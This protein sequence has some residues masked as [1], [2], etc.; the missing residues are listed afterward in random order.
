[1]SEDP[2]ADFYFAAGRVADAAP[3]YHDL[4]GRLGK[5]RRTK[6]QARLFYRL[7]GIAEQSGDLAGAVKQYDEAYRIDT[8]HTP[9]LAALGRVYFE[10]QDWEKARRIYRSMLLQNL[11]ERAGVTKADV[12]LQLGE[13]ILHLGQLLGR[14]RENAIVVA[15]REQAAKLAAEK[16]KSLEAVKMAHALSDMELPPEV[17]LSPNVGLISAYE[18]PAQIG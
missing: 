6:E 13:T 3:L 17:S 18:M 16:A 10:Q 1:M 5:G 11:D 15:D 2:L 7:G 8:G 14:E 12:Y 4:I 9:T